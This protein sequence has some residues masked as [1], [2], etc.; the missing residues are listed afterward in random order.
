MKLTSPP[1]ACHTF[2]FTSIVRATAAMKVC[3]NCS[4]GTGRAIVFATA[5]GKLT[6]LYQLNSS[7]ADTDLL[8][9]ASCWNPMTATPSGCYGGGATGGKFRVVRSHLILKYTGV[10]TSAQGV[11]YVYIGPSLRD[12]ATVGEFISL[13]KSSKQTAAYTMRQLMD[14]ISICPSPTGESQRL[15]WGV[16]SSAASAQPTFCDDSGS[17]P[18]K[19]NKANIFQSVYV[20]FDGMVVDESIM[21]EAVIHVESQPSLTNVFLGTP[22]HT[23]PAPPL[24]PKL[25]LGGKGQS[26]FE[27]AL[28][29]GPTIARGGRQLAE[30]IERFEIGAAAPLL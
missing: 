19:Y 21:V 18:G 10:F 5:P 12:D 20:L 16:E 2:P 13:V 3:N 14:G 26:L 11:C 30:M 1:S 24:H 29:W 8:S 22:V 23:G 9:A 7:A 6:S 4:L 28:N 17:N 27:S 25:K 15:Y